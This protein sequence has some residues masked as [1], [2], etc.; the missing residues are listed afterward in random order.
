M[1]MPLLQLT[2]QMVMP[3]ATVTSDRPDGHATVTGMMVM[4]LATVTT[5]RPDGHATV[6]TDRPDGHATGHCNK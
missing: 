6:T 4:P 1:V 3:L 2:G 5:D